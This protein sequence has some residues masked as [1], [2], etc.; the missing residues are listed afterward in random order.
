MR[1]FAA[2]D[3][4]ELR[5][6]RSTTTKSL[7][8]TRRKSVPDRCGLIECTMAEREASRLDQGA[9]AGLARIFSH[10]G[11]SRRAEAAFGLPGGVLPEYRR[12]LFASHRHLHA[13][14]RRVHAQLPVLRGRARQG[15]SARCRR[16]APNR[17]GGRAA[18]LAAR[19]RHVGRSRRPARRR[20][21]A[22]RGHRARDK[23]R[24]RRR[25]GSR[26]WCRTFK[27]CSRASRRWSNRRSTST[28]TISRRCRV[29]IARAPGRPLRSARS[30]CSVM[31]R[32]LRAR[33]G[34]PMFTKAGVM[35]G[36]GETNDNC[37]R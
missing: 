23:S 10:Q 7:S 9:R 33:A 29:S 13:D 25:R 31:R 1:E 30:T 35:L 21:G 19:G 15:A 11:D 14:G 37:S 24:F 22:F 36:L 16:A 8:R 6:E 34:K 27:A 18:G 2:D 4:R 3:A 32:T 26:C 28:T 17:G 5:I 12:M 20:R